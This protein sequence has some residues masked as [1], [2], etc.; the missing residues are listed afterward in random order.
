MRDPMQAKREPMQ[1]LS[2]FSFHDSDGAYVLCDFQ[3]GM[4]LT[5]FV[6]TDPCIHSLTGEFGVTDGG[7]AAMKSFFSQHC[8]NCFCQHSWA[9]A[10]RYGDAAQHAARSGM[11]LF[12]VL[13]GRLVWISWEGHPQWPAVVVPPLPKSR[14][15]QGEG[16]FF[17]PSQDIFQTT[18]VQD[19]DG[20][21]Q[22]QKRQPGNHKVTKRKCRVADP[23]GQLVLYSLGDEMYKWCRPV[24]CSCLLLAG[25]ER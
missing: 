2:H 22:E 1:A 14:L 9:R 18:F 10:A 3:G 16:H 25:K 6:L 15:L 8:C 21:R 20:V 5:H 4:Q 23:Q 13:P 11:T 19:Y 7:E 17:P 12:S 24:T